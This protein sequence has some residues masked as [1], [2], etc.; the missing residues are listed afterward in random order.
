MFFCKFAAKLLYT[1]YSY[2]SKAYNM[3]AKNK[4]KLN[5]RRWAQLLKEID[6]GNVVLVIGQEL[7]SIDVDGKQVLLRDY[8]LGE[9]ADRL[10]VAYEEGMDFANFSLDERKTA[11]ERIDSDPYYETFRIIN[12]LKEKKIEIPTTLSSLL[13]IDKFDKVITTTINDFVYE[14]MKANR[15]TNV[16][17]LEYKKNSMEEDITIGQ[18]NFVYHMFG[19]VAPTDDYVLTDDD[20]LEFMHCW[21]DEERRPKNLASM[22]YN[23][24]L[25]VVGCNYPYW[26]FRF[27]FHSLKYSQTTGSASTLGMLADSKLDSKLVDFLSRMN[28]GVHEDAVN[29]VNELVDR[30]NKYKAKEPHQRKQIFISYASEDID[31]ANQIALAFDSHKFKVWL[32]KESLKVGDEYGDI[33][34]SIIN[35]CDAFIPVLSH[36]TETRKG[37]YRK[38]WG[39]GVSAAEEWNPDKFIFPIKIE[40]ID[41]SSA[42]FKDF[43]D[44]HIISFDPQ[45]PSKCSDEICSEI[46]KRLLKK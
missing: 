22:L 33:I 37:Y 24:Y 7:L 34:K 2:L 4:K 5:D 17:Q 11:W 12:E 15:N 23:K 38:E 1:I 41:I 43:K 39:W 44:L 8:I 27:F 25:L 18:R 16:K 35:D 21:M 32:D 19:K 14:A 30:W 45:T 36:A 3:E 28:A 46:E 10:G 31:I 29:F 6:K 42:V 9:I 26:L 20:M 40:E 13:S